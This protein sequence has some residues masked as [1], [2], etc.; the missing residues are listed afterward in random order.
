MRPTHA[1]TRSA[2]RPGRSS[3]SGGWP[4][5]PSRC[6]R[7]SIHKTECGRASV[8]RTGTVLARQDRAPAGR[9]R[10]G[11]SAP[12]DRAISAAASSSV[13]CAAAP[14]GSST[15]RVDAVVTVTFP[16][17]LDHQV[18]DREPDRPS[19]VGVA[20]V[21]RRGRLAP[22]RRRPDCR[23]RRTARRP[24]PARATAGRSR[25]GTA[26]GR[27]HGAGPLRA[28]PDPPAPAA[29]GRPG[30]DASCRQRLPASIGR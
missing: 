4:P 8:D 9:S 11:R 13:A 25:K 1:S 12:A 22:A 20:A 2:R 19:P 21:D 24:S 14:R 26:T 15:V 28:W 17:R 7:G 27:E 18:V 30:P 3:R 6:R 10:G 29:G 23:R 5:G 16:Q